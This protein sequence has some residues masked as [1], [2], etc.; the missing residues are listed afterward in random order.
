MDISKLVTWGRLTKK[1]TFNVEGD[2][3]VFH[4]ASPEAEV[5]SRL[6]N[7]NDSLGIIVSCVTKVERPKANEVQEI[8]TV[9]D[10]KW[11]H[12]LLGKMQTNGIVWKLSTL[13]SDMAKEQQET[14]ENFTKVS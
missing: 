3:F 1:V 13:C 12:G 6:I 7:A 14:T 5:V 10:A 2:E 8:V 4:L 11:L 9:D